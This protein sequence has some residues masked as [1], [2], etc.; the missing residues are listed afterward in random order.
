MYAIF[1][2]N[3]LYKISDQKIENKKCLEIGKDIIWK[4]EILR[5]AKI[6]VSLPKGDD[7]VINKKKGIIAR[8]GVKKVINA[9]DMRPTDIVIREYEK[10]RIKTNDNNEF[11]LRTDKEIIDD[12]K[13]KIIDL[14]TKSIDPKYII[15]GTAKEKIDL[16]CKDLSGV[17]GLE[18][19]REIYNKALVGVFE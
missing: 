11:L 9:I 13:Q 7:V 17:G 10:E 3:I 6:L 12:M 8:G 16:F 1:E 19:I 5:G 14:Y 15:D 2:N 18:E 4:I